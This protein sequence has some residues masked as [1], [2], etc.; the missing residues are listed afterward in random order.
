MNGETGHLVDVSEMSELELNRLKNRGYIQVSEEDK[1]KSLKI[2]G[3]KKEVYAVD[4]M[5]DF[6]KRERLKRERRS[7]LKKTKKRRR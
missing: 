2:L 6:T 4:G 5:E 3:T 1:E 7:R